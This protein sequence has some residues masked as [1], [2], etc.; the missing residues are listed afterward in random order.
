[1]RF[2]LKVKK[3][4]RREKS[5]IAQIKSEYI[6]KYGSTNLPQEQLDELFEHEKIGFGL[7][8]EE[9]AN[10]YTWLLLE[11]MDK[12]LLQQPDFYSRGQ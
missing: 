12:L 1:M 10:A 6:K 8:Q 9:I 5:Q 3:I 4:R 11:Q 7:T 2:R